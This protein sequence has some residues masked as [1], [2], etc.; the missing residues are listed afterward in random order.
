VI[1]TGGICGWDSRDHY[2][3]AGTFD[4]L[5]YIHGI[6]GSS[7]TEY[8]FYLSIYTSGYELR[9]RVP[10]YTCSSD[11]D[12]DGR[13]VFIQGDLVLSLG[14]VGSLAII[15]F[16]TPVKDTRDMVFL[17]WAIAVGLGCGTLHW[18]YV[19]IATLFMSFL[20]TLFYVIK[21]GR[22]IHSEYILILAGSTP[23][24]YQSIEQ[25]VTG[26]NIHV[27]LRN[28]EIDGDTWEI[29]Y[30]FRFDRKLEQRV[31]RI[32]TEA[33]KVK[34]V[35]KVSLLTPQLTLPM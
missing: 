7:R 32:V 34:G 13:D 12:C 9:K 4:K 3:A 29:T 35:H 30:E 11:T 21:Y 5:P 1:N 25:I 27:Q 17:F 14:L 23:Y 20:L 33:R 19:V 24:D 28:H 16:R 18:T 8:S 22:Q 31:Q 26:K 15:R 6:I 2:G 10:L